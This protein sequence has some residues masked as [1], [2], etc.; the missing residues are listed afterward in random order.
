[1]KSVSPSPGHKSMPIHVRTTVRCLIKSGTLC[2][3]QVLWI[4]SAIYCISFTVVLMLISVPSSG[5]SENQQPVLCMVAIAINTTGL[6][7]REMESDR[8][9]SPILFKYS[10]FY[11][12]KL[13]QRGTCKLH[14]S[15]GIERQHWPVESSECR[16]LHFPVFLQ[17]SSCVSSGD[18]SRWYSNCRSQKLPYETKEEK[19]NIL[20]SVQQLLS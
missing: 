14:F 7:G 20:I 5:C 10:F 4:C 15:F 9:N 12:L 17:S 11:I 19:N 13:Y 18:G 3:A 2:A 6:N 8:C 1:M 16:Y